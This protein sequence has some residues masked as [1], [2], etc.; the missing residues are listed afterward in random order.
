MNQLPDH[1][2]TMTVAL[3]DVAAGHREQVAAS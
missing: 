1:R 3:S 2:T